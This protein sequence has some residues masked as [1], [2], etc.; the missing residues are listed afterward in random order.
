MKKAALVTSG[1]FLNDQV[2]NIDDPVMNKDNCRVPFFRLRAKMAERGYALATQDIHPVDECSIVIFNDM[3]VN[4]PKKKPN[5]KFFLL[6]YESIAVLPRNFDMKLYRQMDKIFTW[7]DD[8]VDGDRIVK[9]NYS[10]ILEPMPWFERKDRKKLVCLV[11][12]NKLSPHRNELYSERVRAI[13]WFEKHHPEDFDLFGIG[14]NYSFGGYYIMKLQ[15]IF[16]PFRWLWSF[17]RLLRLDRLISRKYMTYRGS[18]SP[19]IPTLRNYQ[20][21]ICFENVSGVPGYITEKI[22]DCFFAGCVPVYLGAPNIADHIPSS[23]YIDMRKFNSFDQLYRYLRDMSDAEFCRYTD[24]IADFLRSSK[25]KA[26]DADV[27]AETIALHCTADAVNRPGVK[28]NP[29]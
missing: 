9:I 12:N 5:Q 17:F 24:A 11:S 2:F 27:F 20:F 7:K 21:N 14:W 29:D 25:A 16:P 28:N 23:C 19:K 10:Y 6:A 4:L 3:P 26:F 1:I 18:L 22:F 13:H 8:I 15:E